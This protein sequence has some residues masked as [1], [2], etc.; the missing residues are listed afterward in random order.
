[1]TGTEAIDYLG[2][3]DGIQH[4]NQEN[5]QLAIIE[6]A[7]DRGYSIGFFDIMTVEYAQAKTDGVHDDEFF[8]GFEYDPNDLT[9]VANDAVEYLNDLGLLPTGYGPDRPHYDDGF[10]LLPTDG[11][12]S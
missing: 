1:M 12:G 3:L 6:F 9:L 7:T 5:R 8:E 4:L 11:E 10:G 2:L